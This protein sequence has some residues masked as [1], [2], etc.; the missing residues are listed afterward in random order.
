MRVLWFASVMAA[1]PLCGASYYTVRLDDPKAVYLTREGFPV[2]GDGAGDDTDALQRAIDRVQ[3][4]DGQG[5]VFVPEGRY[6]LSRTINVWPGIRLIGYGATRPVLV[7]GENTPGYQDPDREKLMVF[8]AGGRRGGQ[9]QDAGAGTF[10]SALSNLDLEIQDG[11]AGAVGVRAHYAQHCFLAHMDIHIGSGLAGIH[12]GGNVRRGRALLR[13]PVRGLDAH[14]FAG[15]A[16]HPGGYHVRRAARSRHS[17]AGRRADA[18]PAALPECSDGDCH[19]SRFSG[20]PLGQGCPHGEHLRSGGGHQPG[21]QRPE[22]DQHGERS[23]QPRPRVRPASRERAEGGR[24][25]R[26]LR[27]K[28]FFARAAFRG[29]RRH[30]GEPG[31]L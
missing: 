1:M 6:R 23:V 25:G 10:Y 16:V 13:R 2:H 26:D 3:E 27:C 9:V 28:G 4:T 7:L 11:N 20:R 31:D 18:D 8:F 24:A 19:R 22:S 12:E 17:G 29:P 15:L 5:I 30:S 14:A 21:E